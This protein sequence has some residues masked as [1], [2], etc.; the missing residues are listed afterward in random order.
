M[1]Y[2]W[3]TPFEAR[4]PNATI[5]GKLF[6]EWLAPNMSVKQ[7]R[8]HL[9]P[10]EEYIN[11]ADLGDAIS[12]SG[13]GE[14]HPD[15]TKG[16]ASVNDPDTAG[17]PVRLGSRLLDEQALSTPVSELMVALRNASGGSA[18]WPILGHVIAGPGTWSPRGGIA[19]GSDAVL[20]AWRKTCMQ[21]GKISPSLC[22][23]HALTGSPT[24]LPR[25]WDHLNQ[26][27]FDQITTSLRTQDV[28]VLRDLAPD[29]G[30]YVNEA[31]PTEPN[32][33]DTFYGENYPRLLALK[34]QWDPHGVFWYKNAVGSEIWEP[35]G[36]HGIE[37]GVGQK[38]VQLCKAEHG[39]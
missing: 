5:Q 16:Y 9:A 19:G 39:M 4:E 17:I 10:L 14:E 21:M 13:N 1:G 23:K 12:V 15:Y 7:V 6:G 11:S 25:S 22:N 35:Q 36:S 24:A 26:T 8:Q 34:K 32:W 37:N 3:V 20:P 29:M 33:K 31:D 38:P 28:Q 2:F 27:Q 18:R 30:A